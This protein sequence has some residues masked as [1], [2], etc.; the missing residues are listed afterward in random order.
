VAGVFVVGVLAV[1][2]WEP[3]AAVWPV[4]EPLGV[5]NGCGTVPGRDGEGD[6]AVVGVWDTEVD[7]VA[8]LDGEVDGAGAL[9]RGDGDTVGAARLGEVALAAG[10]GLA[11]RWLA[12]ARG[13]AVARGWLAGW[14]WVLPCG[15]DLGLAAAA[16]ALDD[17]AL[18]AAA[19][20]S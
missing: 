16:G 2:A 6:G 5:A 4:P 9:A 3:P 19:E 12:L 17:G 11:C 7:G 14:D 15:W 20:A 8:V 13:C 18:A 1:G 10:L